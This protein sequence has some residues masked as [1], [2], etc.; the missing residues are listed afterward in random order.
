[1]NLT[2]LHNLVD[3]AIKN[4]SKGDLSAA[5]SELELV[6]T[7]ITKRNKLIHFADKSP[8]GWTAVKEYKLNR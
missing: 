7:F 8:A 2:S 6:K 3:G 5:I 1:M 4:I